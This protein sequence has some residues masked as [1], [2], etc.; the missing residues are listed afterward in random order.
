MKKIFN[1]IL[2][3]MIV[4]GTSSCKKYLDIN[5]NPNTSTVGPVDLVLP[6]AITATAALSNT[7]SNSLGNIAGATANIFGVGGYGAYLNYNYV[8]ADFNGLW[9]TGYDVANDYNYVISQT[10]ASSSLV[11]STSMARI[12]KA[13]VMSKLVDQFNDIPYSEAFQGQANLAPK[14]DD[15]LT[16]YK[17]LVAQLNTAITAIT[18]GQA[19]NVATPGSVVVPNV[20]A[21]PL[22]RND[23][24]AWKRFAN[25]LKL[26]LLIK[27][28][29]SNKDAAFA[30]AQ[31]ASF[32][33]TI[34]IITD[35]AVVNPGY[36]KDPGRQ[37]PTY[38]SWGYSVAGVRANAQRIPTN[39][40]LAFYNGNKLNDTKRGSVIFRN[41]P[42]PAVNQL[43]NE[44]TTSSQVPPTGVHPATGQSLSSSSWF[45]GTVAG[46]D[47]L[48]FIKGAT[49]G[50]PIMLLAEARFLQAEAYQRGYLTGTASTSF[51]EGIKASIRYLYKSAGGVVDGSVDTDA[52]LTAE[53]T[54]Y[55]AA[56]ASATA[57]PLV[58][59]TPGREIEAIITQ[60]YIALLYITSDEAFNEYRRTAFPTTVNNSLVA[61]ASFAS[62]LSNSTRTDRLPARLPYPSSEFTTNAGNIP[63]VNI[64][65]SLIF[66]DLD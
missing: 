5:T 28:A 8:T 32:D 14:Y 42:T 47:A 50:Q 58:N 12:G 60:K 62:R 43:G 39:W 22:F 3:G 61:T 15:A 29:T 45:T 44:N 13:F 6:Q 9:T 53:L 10:E 57:A 64:F 27:I 30:T 46:G 17:D 2:L 36:I 25:T 38:D 24:N 34:G 63:S 49:Q 16:I 59:L 20:N 41:F 51:D 35:D 37:N 56:N 4:I 33:N 7:Y 52:E 11:Y 23:M 66:W 21:D 1:L 18:T 19:A 48:G 54:A 55:K 65:T 31:F 40:I 26:R